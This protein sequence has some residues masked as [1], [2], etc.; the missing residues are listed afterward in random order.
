MIYK[1]SHFGMIVSE[2]HIELQIS[3]DSLSMKS[4]ERVRRMAAD[5]PESMSEE[6]LLTVEGEGK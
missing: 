4:S 2:M 5:R 6:K 1:E 3:H